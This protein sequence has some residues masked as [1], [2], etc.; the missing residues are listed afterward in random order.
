MSP[1]ILQAAPKGPRPTF[2]PLFYALAGCGLLHAWL[3][4]IKAS[5]KA[6]ILAAVPALALVALSTMRAS[7][8]LRSM[9][10]EESVPSPNSRWA[11]ARGALLLLFVGAAFGLLV[12][13]G[14]VF[15]LALAALSFTFAP[16]AW[17]PFGKHNVGLP[18]LITA[19]GFVSVILRG[20]R[21]IGFMVFPLAAWAFWISAC[22]P[23][24]L[25][26]EQ[27]WREEQARKAKDVSA[28]AEVQAAACDG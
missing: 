9:E 19:I 4:L 28:G 13:N 27:S 17:L 26:I 11:A 15:L 1:R 3:V 12:V 6:H 24:L 25:R 10:K 21:D 2:V 14:S 22:C 20:F 18:V 8:D 7:A 16:P 5:S 23:L